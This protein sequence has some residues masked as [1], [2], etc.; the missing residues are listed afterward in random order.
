MDEAIRR[1]S[2][3]VT[4]GAEMIFPEGLQSEEEFDQF[5]KAMVDLP[6]PKGR[7]Q[8]AGPY[9]LA[10]MTEFGKTPLIP[11]ERFAKMGY[12]CVIFPVSML[13]VAMG[14]VT[15]ALKQLQQSGSVEAFVNQMQTRQEL[16]A[17]VKYTPGKPWEMPA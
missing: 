11:V 10:N 6:S 2:E 15:R 4:A 8:G 7:R 9:L 17:A 1:A 14:A 12:S 16:Y 3:Y 13:R 5:A